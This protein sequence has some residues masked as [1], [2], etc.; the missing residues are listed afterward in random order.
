MKTLRYIIIALTFFSSI[1]FSSGGPPPAPPLFK[2][3]NKGA[4]YQ[5]PLITGKNTNAI[6][7]R[8]SYVAVSELD[9]KIKMDGTSTNP[10][11]TIEGKNFEWQTPSMLFD[12]GISA[13]LSEN[14]ALIINVGLNKMEQLKISG[15]EMAYCGMLV[16][17][18]NHKFRL[19]LGINIHPT[20]YQWYTDS[21]SYSMIQ[22][23]KDDY[24]PTIGF[25][26]NSDFDN[27]LFNPFVQF[28][29]SCQTLYDS[30]DEEYSTEVYKN[31]NVF[32]CTPGICYNFND[33][34]RSVFGV[35]FNY[36]D[37]IENS[38]SFVLTPQLQ[39]SF[40]W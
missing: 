30:G 37:K 22:S 31:V 8:L 16:N 10:Q 4:V 33:N 17:D 13:R 28:S 39:F 21:I 2:A 15:F 20:D 19:M 1:S 34:L 14:A 25:I 7:A 40:Y 5:A 36:V 11:G 35:T 6:F 3:K 24:D 23:S 38:E 29:Y 9:G 12:F 26:Y 27:W 32:S 18:E